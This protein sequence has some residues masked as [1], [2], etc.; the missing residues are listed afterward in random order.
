MRLLAR[1]EPVLF[2]LVYGLSLTALPVARQVFPSSL[3]ETA[4]PSRD[5]RTDEELPSLLA[6]PPVIRLLDLTYGQV[7]HSQLKERLLTFLKNHAARLE[8]QM[9]NQ[10]RAN[11]D[12]LK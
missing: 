6:L 1:E 9:K 4:I 7:L 8:E 2:R 3:D 11:L 12:R 5:E 10:V